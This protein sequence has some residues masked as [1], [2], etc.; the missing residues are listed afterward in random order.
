VN[1]P[2][3]DLPLPSA[4][5][6]ATETAARRIWL[7]SPYISVA[8]NSRVQPYTS[9]VNAIDFCQAFRSL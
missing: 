7:V 8:G 9:K 4:M 3:L 1:S 5:L 2:S 6:L